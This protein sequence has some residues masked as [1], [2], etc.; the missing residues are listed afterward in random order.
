MEIVEVAVQL[1]FENQRADSIAMST[2]VFFREKAEV[3]IGK[4]VFL[5]LELA[6]LLWQNGLGNFSNLT[7]GGIK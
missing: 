1:F 6:D 4:E 5:K 7:F 2:V 3:S